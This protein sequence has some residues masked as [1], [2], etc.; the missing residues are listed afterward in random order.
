MLI[1]NQ[2]IALKGH[3]MRSIINGYKVGWNYI[4]AEAATMECPG[5]PEEYEIYEVI[6]SKGEDIYEDLP[7]S[8]IDE[9]ED[10]LRAL[11]GERDA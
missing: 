3:L 4:E 10:E 7:D 5:R 6:N 11:R 2:N 9:I 8:V 1:T